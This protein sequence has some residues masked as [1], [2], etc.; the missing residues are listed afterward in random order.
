LKRFFIAAA[1][2]LA[3]LLT[4]AVTASAGGVIHDVMATVIGSG[5]LGV[6]WSAIDSDEPLYTVTCQ[7]QDSDRS[8][9]R[10]TYH[11]YC[12]IHNLSP[13]TTY[14]IT[15]T[16]K[17]GS[18]GSVT[19]TIPKPGYFMGFGYQLLETGVYQSTAYEDDYTA[20][21]TLNGAELAT[22]LTSYDFSFLLKFNVT[23]SRNTKYLDFE[24]SL[25]MPNGDVYNLSPVLEFAYYRTT[26]TE[27]IPFN[28]LLK[29]IVSDYGS[30]PAGDYQLTAYI[31]SGIAGEATFTVE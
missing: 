6:S 12:K 21:T 20:V 25:R 23:S 30:I 22:Q 8:T 10:R 19:I 27:Y 16:T 31:N 2:I 24:L 15:V 14:V 18:T 11:T 5:S 1:L 9:E 17:D 26:I 13:E 28:R 3:L 7:V 29:K 4:S